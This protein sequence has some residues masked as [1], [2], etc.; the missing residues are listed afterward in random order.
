MQVFQTTNNPNT[1]KY[2]GLTYP[3]NFMCIKQGSE[4]IAIHNAYDTRF[5]LM[6]S[7]HFNQI[8]VNGVN[9]TSQ[10]DLMDNLAT[11]IYAKQFNYLSQINGQNQLLSIGNI[12]LTG[13]TLTVEP[14]QW[15][16]NGTN[17]QTT[18]NSIINVP[19]AASGKSRIDLIIANEYN[20]IVRYSGV[21]YED[22][23]T[24][25]V[26]PLNAI[27]ITQ[28]TASD[29]HVGE[30]TP[31]YVGTEYVR[32]SYLGSYVEPISGSSVSLSFEVNG[33][34]TIVLT[35]TGLTSVSG[36]HY[37][38]V[39]EIDQTPFLG[40]EYLFYNYTGHDVIFKQNDTSA[41]LPFFLTDQVNTT[42]KNNGRIRFQFNGSGFNE[43]FRSISE[44]TPAT[45]LTQS[46]WSFSDF[47]IAQGNGILNGTS[48]AGGAFENLQ[49]YSTK[50]A[51][52]I[53][54][55]TTINSGYQLWSMYNARPIGG[56]FYCE[57]M[58]NG[59][60]T[61]RDTRIGWLQGVHGNEACLVTDSTG[62]YA[63]CKNAATG[64]ATASSFVSE[65]LINDQ[66]YALLIDF[67]S[68]TQ[69][70]FK[71]KKLSTN[72]VIL[73]VSITTNNA[74]SYS[75]GAFGVQSKRTISTGSADVLLVLDYVGFGAEKPNFLL[76]F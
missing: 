69:T 70:N 24:A 3:K 26:L 55:Q 5:Q 48:I 61:E 18:L 27:Y 32:K 64:L 10:A 57:F 4:S 31:I 68:A 43:V 2:N 12:S 22:I 33:K 50:G 9:H 14:A 58:H 1:F 74:P 51:G 65:A 20:Q 40:K 16:I 66:F 25:P 11:L 59:T 75:F 38:F 28:I 76:N 45:T 46:R 6:G 29:N 21:E 54:H 37:E 67:V 49:S 13:N 35:S 34:S 62:T 42:L 72:T 41:E 19:F 53:K 44:P 36:F 30:P 56:S 17:Y 73:N 60:F 52:L 8:Q 47:Y 71:L 63:Y 7:T 23:G 39:H 15:N